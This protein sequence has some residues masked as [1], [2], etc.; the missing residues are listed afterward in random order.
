MGIWRTPVFF[1]VD[2]TSSS[3][4]R[5]VQEMI[6]RVMTLAAAVVQA[7]PSQ[8]LICLTISALL[9][10]PTTAPTVLHTTTRLTCG[11]PSKVAVRRRGASS[12]TVMSRLLATGSMFSTSNI[13]LYISR[14][15]SADTSYSL[16][17]TAEIACN[18]AAPYPFTHA[19]LRGCS[20]RSAAEGDL[21]HR[22]DAGNRTN[23]TAKTHRDQRRNLHRGM[24][25]IF[26]D[27]L[28]TKRCVV[29][30]RD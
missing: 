27:D 6:F 2:Q 26:D 4:S 23:K 16:G 18:N 19:S 24:D 10:M 5:R 21:R 28:Q 3:L 20:I 9:K 25:V 30:E 29:K 11:A 7:R 1:I 8:R 15:A 17:P 13:Y 12:P 22:Q 14:R